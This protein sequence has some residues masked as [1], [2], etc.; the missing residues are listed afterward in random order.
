MSKPR[1][2]NT[3]LGYEIYAGRGRVPS[4][5]DGQENLPEKMAFHLGSQNKKELP[6]LSTKEI[7]S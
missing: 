1:Y 7:L 4:E 3:M 2:I 6:R 5:V